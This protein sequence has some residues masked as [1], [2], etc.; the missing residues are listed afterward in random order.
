ML[1]RSPK[2]LKGLKE[3]QEV[4]LA[5][6]LET[7][8]RNTQSII[9]SGMKNTAAQRAI[10]TAMQ[11]DMAERRNDVSYAPGVVTVLEKGKPVSYNVADQLFIDAV[12]SLNLPELPFLSF[13]AAPANLLRNMVTKDPGFMMANLMRD[14]LSAWVTSGE[15]GRAH[16]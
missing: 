15:I 5:D 16:V 4:P 7:V 13:F 12:K 1:F 9:Q 6:F 3:G 11:L 14:S 2:K 8:V 10:G